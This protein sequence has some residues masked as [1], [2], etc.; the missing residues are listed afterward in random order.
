[1]GRTNDISFLE[2][3]TVDVV[4]VL[5]R[6]RMPVRDLLALDTGAVVTLDRFAGE[7]LDVEVDGVVIARGE[8]VVVDGRFGVRITE[9]LPVHV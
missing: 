6:T 7:P 5:G 3:V 9:V 1:M 4:V 2:D 8:V